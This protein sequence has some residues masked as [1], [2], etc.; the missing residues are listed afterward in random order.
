MHKIIKYS[1]IARMED[2]QF[3]IDHHKKKIELEHKVIDLLNK[4]DIPGIPRDERLHKEGYVRRDLILGQLNFIAALFENPVP[5]WVTNSEWAEDIRTR[6]IYRNPFESP[7]QLQIFR[8][9]IYDEFMQKGLYALL[10]DILEEQGIDNPDE[11][12][13]QIIENAGKNSV[14]YLLLTLQGYLEEMHEADMWSYK[15]RPIPEE[16]EEDRTKIFTEKFHIKNKEAKIIFEDKD[17]FVVQPLNRAAA[18][19]Y[20]GFEEDLNNYYLNTFKDSINLIIYSK[21]DFVDEAGRSQY[22]TWSYGSLDEDA[23]DMDNGYE[24]MSAAQFTQEYPGIAKE[25]NARMFNP[26]QY[27]KLQQVFPNEIGI[28]LLINDIT[29]VVEKNN[30]YSSASLIQEVLGEG[31]HFD[32]DYPGLDYLSQYYPINPEHLKKIQGHFVAKYPQEDFS[33]INWKNSEEVYALIE[34]YS[35]EDL[36]DALQ[37]AYVYAQ[38]EAMYS[39]LA[40]AARNVLAEHYGVDFSRWYPGEVVYVPEAKVKEHWD[41]FADIFPDQLQKRGEVLL[42]GLAEELLDESDLHFAVEKA[43]NNSYVTEEDYNQ[44]LSDTLGDVI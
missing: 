6:G 28:G 34:E 29:E 32:F 5:E 41:V 19:F 14:G 40:E 9:R 2:V 25:I 20:L 23:V 38:E 35:E 24:R 44:Y 13:D 8:D 16:V 42:T 10:Q 11:T 36:G 15:D 39:N 22:F 30:R 12:L 33:A 18:E 17:W 26:E 21:S 31:Y 1:K 3:I 4:V 37:K 27:Q 7:E 43:E